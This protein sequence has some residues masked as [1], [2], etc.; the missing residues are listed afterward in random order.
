MLGCRNPHMPA[1]H[2]EKTTY[3]RIAKNSRPTSAVQFQ[4]SLEK[5][6]DMFWVSA[7]LITVR[8]VGGHDEDS[9][10]AIYLFWLS[11]LHSKRCKVFGNPSERE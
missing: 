7:T 1:G 10:A 2:S 11:W 9:P 8:E 6:A 4:S 3:N 5:K